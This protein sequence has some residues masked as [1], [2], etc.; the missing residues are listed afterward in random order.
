[1]IQLTYEPAF[2][3]YHAAFRSL[4]L[5]PIFRK[6][7]PL[8]RDHVR[9]ID[10]YQLFPHRIEGIRLLPQHRKFRRLAKAY[11]VKKPYGEQPDDRLLFD[12][13]EPLQMT[14]LDTLSAL[15]YIEGDSWKRGEVIA[16]AKPLPEPLAQRIEEANLADAELEAFLSILGSDY[17]LVGSNGLKARTGLLEHRHDAV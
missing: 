4:R 7:N 3:A 16:T 6:E 9:I 2:D 8:H 14:A 5:R 17:D 15:E 13:M 10:F 1:M 12:R 11:E